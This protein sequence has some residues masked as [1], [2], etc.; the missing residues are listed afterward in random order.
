MIA[1]NVSKE[2]INALVKQFTATIFLVIYLNIFSRV[3]GFYPPPYFKANWIAQAK[4]CFP[5]LSV[6]GLVR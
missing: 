4:F 1:L 2:T 5:I 6:V 3:L